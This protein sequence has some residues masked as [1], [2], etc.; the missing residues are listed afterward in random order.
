MEWLGAIR[1]VA[2]A[3]EARIL[4]K[5]MPELDDKYTV[6]DQNEKRKNELSEHIDRLEAFESLSG[7]IK[8]VLEAELEKLEADSSA[9]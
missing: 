9:V 3:N 1:G 5:L 2:R 7:E 6:Q 4:L 8:S